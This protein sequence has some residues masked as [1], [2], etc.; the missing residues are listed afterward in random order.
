MRKFQSVE[1]ATVAL[2][3]V[4]YAAWL[5]AGLLWAT[6]WW[7]ISLP[8]M[9]VAAA[10]HSSLQH[11]A[12][13]N[14]PTENAQVNEALI[15]LPLQLIFPFRR[16]RDLHLAHHRDIH[17]TDPLED[18]ESYYWP[19]EAYTAMRPVMKR[20][21]AINN[22]ML[23][24][25]VLG[26]WLT[27]FGFARTEWGRVMRREPGVLR[28]WLHHGVAVAVSLAIITFVFGMP[29][30]VYG[31]CV[32]YPSMAI[33]A[34]RAYAEHQAAENV[35]ERSAVV[36]TNPALSLLYLNNNLHIV[37][38]ASP[39][40]AWY[41]IPSLYRERQQQYLAANG[42]YRFHG[43]RDVWRRFAFSVKQPVY[44]PLARRDVEAAE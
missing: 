38:H 44:H 36:E 30:W 25:L 2:I 32:I 41:D 1:W 39:G 13:H 7:I 14:H 29:L 11:E 20:V 3:A 34:M 21:F 17:L 43:Y 12:I 8:I 27:L 24:R 22:T 18:P 42:N 5:G 15:W 35:G 33:I 6:A 31:L 26:P 40:T 10:F 37:H 23:G 16:Y 4:C 9:A 19:L 28:S